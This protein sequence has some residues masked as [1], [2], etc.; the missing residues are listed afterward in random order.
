[1]FAPISVSAESWKKK[2]VGGWVGDIYIY[3]GRY[4]DVLVNRVL[5]DGKSS[6]RMASSG[7]ARM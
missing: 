5:A 3:K 6:S 2:W 1:M 4:L 7:C